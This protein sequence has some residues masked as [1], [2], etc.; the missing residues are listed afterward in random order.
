[1]THLFCNPKAGML[2]GKKYDILLIP[3]YTS[4]K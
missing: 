4:N 2:S 3:G 1:M